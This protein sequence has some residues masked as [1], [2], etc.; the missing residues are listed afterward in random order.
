MTSGWVVGEK[1]VLASGEVATMG[2]DV[3][4]DQSPLFL[5]NGERVDEKRAQEIAETVLMR[6]GTSKSSQKFKA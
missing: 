6:N 1:F 3:D 2:E 5:A 4:L